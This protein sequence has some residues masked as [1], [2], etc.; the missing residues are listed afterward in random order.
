MNVNAGSTSVRLPFKLEATNGTA[1][2]AAWNTASL[3]TTYARE[4]E[5]PV[6]ITRASQTPTGAWTSGG[7]CPLGALSP[8]HHR[9][10]APDAAFAPGARWV[11]FSV[12][13]ATGMRQADLRVDLTEDM[14]V[15]IRNDILD[16]VLEDNHNVMGSL[17]AALQGFLGKPDEWTD[18]TVKSYLARIDVSTNLVTQR[19][20]LFSAPSDSVY[21]WKTWVNGRLEIIEAAIADLP[22]AVQN[23]P[24]DAPDA[25]T[26][27]AASVAGAVAAVV[28]MQEVKKVPRSDIEVAAGGVTSHFRTSGTEPDEDIVQITT[29]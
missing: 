12:Y 13:G 5:D 26:V 17:G 19:L 2:E 4:G 23:V 11:T 16:R 1:F 3:V 18:D 21:D 7:F 14:V 25:N 22:L 20:G 28:A 10:D 15:A 9:L 29:P 8:G 27:G 6:T 24:D